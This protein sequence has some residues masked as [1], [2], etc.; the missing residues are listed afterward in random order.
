MTSTICATCAG[1]ADTRCF[2]EKE[3]RPTEKDMEGQRKE[4][5]DQVP[6]D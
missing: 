6:T 5:H 3:Q 1:H 4:R 2:W